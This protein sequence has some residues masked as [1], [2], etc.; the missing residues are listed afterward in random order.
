MLDAHTSTPRDPMSLVRDP[1]S[2]H[3][4][5]EDDLSL[6]AGN[7]AATTRPVRTWDLWRYGLLAALLAL[8]G[9]WFLFA[10]RS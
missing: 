3:I 6:G 7:V 2:S 10:R 5:P 1:G 8:S 9:E 4:A